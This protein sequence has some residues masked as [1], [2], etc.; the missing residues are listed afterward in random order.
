MI[1]KPNR[2]GGSW[3][4]MPAASV[5]SR[6]PSMHLRSLRQKGADEH[7]AH[8]MRDEVYG[9]GFSAAASLDLRLEV[10]NQRVEWFSC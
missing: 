8:R 1:P 4:A 2:I 10:C 3:R 5:P 7:A 6:A 9:L